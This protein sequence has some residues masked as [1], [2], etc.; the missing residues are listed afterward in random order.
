VT[1]KGGGFPKNG[2]KVGSSKFLLRDRGGEPKKIRPPRGGGKTALFAHQIENERLG[3]KGGVPNFKK[4]KELL[5]YEEGPT[6][7]F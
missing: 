7:V 1:T 2:G 5:K 4:L 3:G 6:G